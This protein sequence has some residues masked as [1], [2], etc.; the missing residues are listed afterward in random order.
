MKKTVVSTVLALALL[1]TVSVNAAGN[2]LKSVSSPNLTFSGTTAKC[3]A[4]I[5]EYSKQINVTMELWTGNTLLKTWTET[6]RDYVEVKGEY[7]SVE[8]G[9][10]Y[11]LKVYGTLGGIA[12]SAR[13]RSKTA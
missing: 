8:H 7:S 6:G 3:S 9:K 12:F 5:I 2:S 13:S 4:Q 11:T 1:L 10:T